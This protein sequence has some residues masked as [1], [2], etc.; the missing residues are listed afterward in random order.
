L[1]A[2]NADI[3]LSLDCRQVPSVRLGDAFV[4][5]PDRGALRVDV[6]IGQIGL[7]ERAADRFRVSRSSAERRQTNPSQEGRAQEGARLSAARC[8]APFLKCA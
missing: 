4:R 2:F 8:N 3:P 6:G 7:D 1:G 5:H